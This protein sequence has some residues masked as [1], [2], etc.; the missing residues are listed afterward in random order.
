MNRVLKYEKK[1]KELQNDA[2]DIAKKMAEP[3]QKQDDFMK[4]HNKRTNIIYDI[5]SYKLAH[6]L[7]YCWRIKIRL[8]YLFFIRVVFPFCLRTY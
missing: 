4:L 8:F 7:F 5:H 1:I 6:Q 2:D 3:N